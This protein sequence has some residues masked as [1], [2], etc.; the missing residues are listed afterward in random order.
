M[1]AVMQQTSGDK[2]D[3]RRQQV[4]VRLFDAWLDRDCERV[5]SFF[6]EDSVF[7]PAEGERRTGAEA[8]WAALGSDD[9]VERELLDISAD[10]SGCILARHRERRLVDGRWNERRVLGVLAVEG[11]KIRSWRD[12]P[13]D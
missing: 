4:V 6:R 8:I 12:S 11:C 2:N 9:A 1:T 13:G 5:Q 10:D 7:E 3:T